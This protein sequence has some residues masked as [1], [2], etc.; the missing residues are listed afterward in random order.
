VP[1]THSTA[2]AAQTSKGCPAATLVL[3]CK[4]SSGPVSRQLR[5]AISVAP[6]PRTPLVA[7]GQQAD[8]WRRIV[9]AARLR[10]PRLATRGRGRERRTGVPAHFLVAHSALE[11]GWGKREL[12]TC[13]RLA[14]FQ[15]LRDQGRA[16]LVGSDRRSAHDRVRQWHAADGTRDVPRLRFLRRGLSRLRRAS[17]Q[18]TRATPASSASRMAYSLPVPCSEAGYATDPMYADKLARI[19]G[20]NTLRQALSARPDLASR[21]GLNIRAA[22]PLTEPSTRNSSHGL[23]NPWYRSV[24]GL[25]VA[26]QHGLQTTEHNIANANT[27][28]YT[29]QRVHPGQQCRRATGSGFLGQG[30]HVATIERVYSR[31]LTEQVDRSQSGASELDTYVT[32]KSSRS[33]ICWPT[34]VPACRRRCRV[35]LM[36]SAQVA[37]NPSGLPSRQAMVSNAQGLSARYQSWAINWRRCTTAST[38]DHGQPSPAINSYAEQIAS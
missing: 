38:G 30:T 13:R 4:Q 3:P 33:T 11:S 15:R 34:A 14:Q 31:F 29:R 8:G 12:R 1:V 22:L 16:Q 35:S 27:P 19:I 32:H 36:A 21:E 17:Q 24:S 23:R 18:A 20:G 25:H 7:G 26:A 9:G 6:P 37:A 5:R 2:V 10:R 28:G